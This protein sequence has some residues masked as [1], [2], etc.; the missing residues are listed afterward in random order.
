MS[1]Y[2]DSREEA[3][4]PNHLLFGRKLSV[5]NYEDE[6]DI[7]LPEP[8]NC[9]KYQ[10]YLLEHFW[11]RWSTE[12]LTSLREF[13]KYQRSKNVANIPNVHDIVIIKEDKLP[14]Q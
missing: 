4:T 11:K 9:I 1:P 7:D 14:R 2:D 8:N 13:Q 3:I 6:L 12:Y 5:I 10:N